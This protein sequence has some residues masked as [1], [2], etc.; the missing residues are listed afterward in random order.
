MNTQVQ[1]RLPS[2]AP[3]QGGL[4]RPMLVVF[5]GLSLVTGLLYPG[6]ITAISRAV[7][8]HQAGGSLIE[9]DGRT[10]GSE[11]IGQPFSDPKYFWGRLSATAPMPY[12]AAASVGSNL[13]PGNPAL[14]DAARAR[15]D[16]LHA[17]DPHNQAPVPVDLVTASGSGLDPHISPAAAG[18]QAA[19][20]ARVRGIPIEQ[21]QQLVAANTETPLLPVLGDPG[22][23][24]L[25]LNLAL[26][27]IARQ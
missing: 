22:V 25:K 6:V 10:L 20:V 7:F 23:N 3:V 24:V 8:P 14:T 5:V 21:V 13:G 9:K 17:A 15:I 4:L 16:A 27:A 11:L 1:S 12:N 18:Y 26:D 19:R 2:P